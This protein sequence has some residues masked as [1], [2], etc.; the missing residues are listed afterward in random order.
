MFDPFDTVVVTNG[1]SLGHC[2]SK[3]HFSTILGQTEDVR[4]QCTSKIYKAAFFIGRKLA[5]CA[6]VRSETPPAAAS[7][8]PDWECGRIEVS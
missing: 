1:G 3:M 4:L 8:E 5:H 6:A 7:A 2:Q